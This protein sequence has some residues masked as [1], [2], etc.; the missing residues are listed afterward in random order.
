M[1][2]YTILIHNCMSAV[3]NN[4]SEPEDEF[5]ESF[6]KPNHP[7]NEKNLFALEAT[8]CDLIDATINEDSRLTRK[9]LEEFLSGKQAMKVLNKKK[10]RPVLDLIMDRLHTAFP[11]AFVN[12]ATV[13]NPGG[14]G[15]I[16]IADNFIGVESA[17]AKRSR[18]RI[19]KYDRSA[20]HVQVQS[21]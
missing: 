11:H 1:T 9:Y 4:C 3:M 18:E 10:L 17:A 8:M 14:M 13:N 7:Q 20:S 2:E 19:R 5:Y 6:Y 21:A 16:K 12:T 15:P